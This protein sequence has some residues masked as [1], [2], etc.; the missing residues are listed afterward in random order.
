M[1]AVAKHDFNATADDELSFQKNDLVK[2]LDMEEDR[3]WYKAEKEGREGFIPANYIKMKPNAWYHGKIKRANCELLLLKKYPNG[4]CIQ[5]DGAF[6]VRLSESTPGDFSLSVKWSDA[7][8]HFKSYETEVG[9][10]SCG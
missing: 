10:T 9:G 2:V 6:V 4:S 8:Q 5:P 1:E 7:V 3:N